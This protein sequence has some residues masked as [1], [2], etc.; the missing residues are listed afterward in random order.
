VLTIGVNRAVVLLAEPAGQRRPGPRLLRELG[1]HPD[2]GTVNLYSG[3]YGPYLSHDG[4]IASLPRAADPDA[5]SLDQAVPLLAAQR[6]KGKRRQRKA[7]KSAAAPPKTR[8]VAK[9]A[10]GAKKAG[11][12]KPRSRLKAPPG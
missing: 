9:A 10:G 11:P 2:G 1:E 5:F 12:R 6:K 3:R 4:V 7:G 8:R